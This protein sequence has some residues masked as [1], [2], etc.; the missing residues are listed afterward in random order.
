MPRA[1]GMKL[2]GGAFVYETIHMRWIC[3]GE[4]HGSNEAQA[5]GGAESLHG[6]PRTGEVT[7]EL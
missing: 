5:A 6:P 2:A 1:K 7:A 3:R 4:E